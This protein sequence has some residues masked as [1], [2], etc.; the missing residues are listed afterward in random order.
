MGDF[1][2]SYRTFKSK[3]SSWERANDE[4]EY[5]VARTR[6]DAGLHTVQQAAYAA[7]TIAESVN[8]AK[9]VALKTT[10]NTLEFAIGQ[11]EA[12]QDGI[13]GAVPNT[14]GVG[15]TVITDPASAVRAAVKGGG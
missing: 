12:I 13:I 7:T 4:F 9:N 8:S 6:R 1:L 5:Q 11:N 3:L 14:V 10:M 2:V 15:M